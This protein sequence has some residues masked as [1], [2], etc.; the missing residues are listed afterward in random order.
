MSTRVLA[1]DA[2]ILTAGGGSG[3]PGRAAPAAPA[4][5]QPADDPGAV[6]LGPGQI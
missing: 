1:T 6:P 3:A 2:A 5:P 4:D